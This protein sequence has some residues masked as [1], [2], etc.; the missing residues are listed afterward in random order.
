MTHLRRDDGFGG[1]ADAF[2]EQLVAA[3]H[4]LSDADSGALN[5]RLVLLLANHVGDANVVTE[6]IAAARLGLGAGGTGTIR[7]VE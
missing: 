6:A 7:S 2:Y 3:H 4:G 1:Q 5:A